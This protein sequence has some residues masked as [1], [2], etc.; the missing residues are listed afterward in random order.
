[1]GSL[2]RATALRGFPELVRELGGDPDA[3]Y[4][5]FGFPVGVEQQDDEFVSV[6]PFGRML[7]VSAAELH[8]RDFGLRLS[9]LRG[10]AMAGPIAV[11]IR[12]SDTVMEA[13]Q[14]GIR[15]S[16]AHSP[17]YSLR[18]ER[19]GDTEVRLVYEVTEPLSYYPLQAYEMS[20]GTLVFANRLLAGS[21]ANLAVSFQH[22]QYGSDAAYRDV[23][24]CQVRFGQTWSGVVSP[25]DVLH[26][27]IDNADPAARAIAIKYLEATHLPSTARLS[28]RVAEL[29]RRL[30]PTGHCSVDAIAEHLAMHPRTLQRRLAADGVSCQQIIDAERR[31]Q[32]TKYLAQPALHLSQIAG[33]LGYAE[34]SAFNRSCQRWFGM[35]PRQYRADSARERAHL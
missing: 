18:F 16:Y 23:L 11:I 26:R 10:I 33:L 31:S 29:A 25:A 9:R 27:R 22:A 14:A 8:C 17:A 19:H 2:I 24:V 35:T 6:Q 15:Y 12:N 21:D 20:V 13:M 7:E 3:Y 1:M 5:R 32:A 34:Q 30:L 28:E 4:S